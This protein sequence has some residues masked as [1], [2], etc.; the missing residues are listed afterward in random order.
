MATRR[1]ARLNPMT[2]D[3]LADDAPRAFDTGIRVHKASD[4][5]YEALKPYFGCSP[6]KTTART[7]ENSTQYG[8]I[9]NSEEGN[10][11]KRYKSP[12]PAMNMH[13]WDEDIPM[14]EIFS[15]VP[16]LN[17]GFKSAM[18]FF[19]RRSHII[20]VEEMT[21]SKR[22]LQCLQ[23]LMTKHG[24]P[25]LSRID[26]KVMPTVL[27]KNTPQDIGINLS[28]RT[29][30]QCHLGTDVVDIQKDGPFLQE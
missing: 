22:L 13:G 17:G 25:N 20:H 15:G 18:V 8:H 27:P 28:T 10:Q 23:N 14:D 12:Q 3:E 26:E 7:F 19:G 1:G 4:K 5:D 16:A 2:N 29:L 24:A 21:R 30:R 6:V 11:F 9:F